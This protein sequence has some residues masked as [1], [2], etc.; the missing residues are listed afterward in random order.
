[1]RDRRRDAGSDQHARLP[2]DPRQYLPG[3]APRAVATPGLLAYFAD[4]ADGRRAAEALREA[5]FEVSVE[6]LQPQPVDS[7]HLGQPR[8]PRVGLEDHGAA[9]LP[10]DP[11]SQLTTVVATSARG[12]RRRRAEGILRR[13]GATLGAPP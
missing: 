4:H 11:Q 1:M 13:F 12:R 5:G 2:D 9:G 8:F 7:A 10:V 6:R 3:G